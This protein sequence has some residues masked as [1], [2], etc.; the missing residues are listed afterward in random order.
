MTPPAP[1]APAPQVA[2]PPSPNA[3]L[4]QG[5]AVDTQTEAPQT[6]VVP[7]FY[8]PLQSELDLAPPKPGLP[9]MFT[10]MEDTHGFV[11]GSIRGFGSE[12]RVRF[13]TNHG[14]TFGTFNFNTFEIGYD[15]LRYGG[16]KIYEQSENKHLSVFLLLPNIDVRVFLSDKRFAGALG[17]SVSG[18]RV[19]NCGLTGCAEIS[20]RLLTLDAWVA[21]DKHD[22]GVAFS[23]GAG[24]SAG[25]KL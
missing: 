21:G 12:T 11:S 3:A 7:E 9:G 18:I 23:V 10:L 16:L 25:L 6:Q 17:T 22:A 19:A 4:A 13:G 14:I 1:V 2:P 15:A 5:V 24:L 20:L 8:R